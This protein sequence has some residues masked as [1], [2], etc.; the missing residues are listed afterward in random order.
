MMYDRGLTVGPGDA[1][2]SEN[3]LTYFAFRVI[4]AVEL[5]ETIKENKCQ[6]KESH[7]QVGYVCHYYKS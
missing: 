3:K 4:T 5:C 1:E 2:R 7:L 6:Y